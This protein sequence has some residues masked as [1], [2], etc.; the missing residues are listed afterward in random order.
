MKENIKSF[1]KSKLYTYNNAFRASVKCVKLVTPLR[2]FF[3]F[4]ITLIILIF[5]PRLMYF[6]ILFC[7]H[8]DFL[9]FA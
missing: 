9:F 8:I 5:S 1:S 2:V 7:K 4:L 3:L 6:P